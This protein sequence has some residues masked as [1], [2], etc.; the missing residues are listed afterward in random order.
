MVD[1]ERLNSVDMSAPDLS[2]IPLANVRKIEVL[3]GPQTVLYGDNSSAGVVNILTDIDGG[4]DDV[5]YSTKTRIG[6]HGGS[7]ETFGGDVAVRTGDAELATIAWANAN[8]EKSRG[9]RGNSG[10]EIWNA[11]GGVKK[12]F[13]NGSFFKFSAFYNDANSRLPQ[14]LSYAKWHSAPR[15]T[16]FEA[17]KYRRISSGFDMQVEG[18]VNDENKVRLDVN[19]AN[20]K[21]RSP[22]WYYGGW[23]DYDWAT[24]LPTDYVSYDSLYAYM[25]DIWSYDFTPQWINTTA[26]FG[27]DNELVA[28]A[29]YR[30]DRLD[31]KTASGTWY[32]PSYYNDWYGAGVKDWSKYRYERQTMAF[33]AQDTLHF[34]D[35]LA[36]Q[37]GARYQRTWSGNTQALKNSRTDNMGAYE[38]ALLFTPADDLKTYVR[39]ARFFR[40]PFLDEV[41]YNQSYQISKLLAPEHGW[42]VDVGGEWRFLDDFSVAADAYIT[43]TKKEI[44]YDATGTP[45]NN[46]NSPS[47][48][49]REGFD[50]RGAWEKDKLAGLAIGYSYVNAEFDGGRYDGNTI[51]CVPEST[52]SLTGRVWLWDDCFIFGGYRYQS[53][54]ISCSDFHNTARKIPAFGLFNI[55]AAYEA[56]SGL[57][58]GWSFRFAI[59]NLL[60]KNY[61][62]WSTYGS[63]YWPGAGRNYQFSVSYAF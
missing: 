23:Q 15:H 58:K 13:E 47:D 10:W 42:S 27:L 35:Y 22:S 9:Y 30:Y 38:A 5:D 26:V 59:D 29:N 63:N 54:Q 39:F 18:V 24:G 53:Y 25:Y 51:P 11:D 56:S 46:V 2:R 8:W 60:D 6:A 52:V 33:F 55:G 48:T 4:K 3:H 17:N 40:N 37:L 50:L 14:Q 19:V 12:F 57:L 62:D 41:P 34:T 49:I 31:G 45:A 20:R 21:M 7:W 44:F 16:D 36:M 28:G 61:C 43:K 1:G 32:S